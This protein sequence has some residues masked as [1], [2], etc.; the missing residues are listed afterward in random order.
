MKLQKAIQAAGYT[1]PLQLEFEDKQPL[2]VLITDIKFHPAKG[3]LEHVTFQE[4]KKGQ[5]VTAEVPIVLIGE[6]A[7]LQQGLIL[8]Q[9]MYSIEVEAGALAYP[10]V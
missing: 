6:A 1:Q 8:I 5:L 2:T 9:T 3:N 7:G 10:R 4:V